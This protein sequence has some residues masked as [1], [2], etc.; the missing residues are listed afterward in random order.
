[1]VLQICQVD[2]SSILKY[3]L[4]NDKKINNNAGVDSKPQKK[5]AYFVTSFLARALH[6]VQVSVIF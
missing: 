1:M 2:I 4:R 3:E 6:A 5:Q